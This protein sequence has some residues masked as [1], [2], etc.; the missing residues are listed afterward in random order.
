MCRGRGDSGLP[1]GGAQV[2]RGR[3]GS[4][5]PGEGGLRCASWGAQLCLAGGLR[6]MGSSVPLLCFLGNGQVRKC[7]PVVPTEP[8]EVTVASQPVEMCLHFLIGFTHPVL[9]GKALPAPGE[10]GQNNSSED[11]WGSQGISHPGQDRVR[12]GDPCGWPCP[13]RR[14]GAGWGAANHRGGPRERPAA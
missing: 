4:G 7:Q 9:S 12:G 13:W 8:P 1:R 10:G 6:Y 11:T 3:V 5:V 2:C 14:E